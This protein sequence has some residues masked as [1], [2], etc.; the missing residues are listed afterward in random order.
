[1][2]RNCSQVNVMKKINKKEWTLLIV[3]CIIYSAS[4][5]SI[6]HATMVPGS[7]L[8]LALAVNKV[9]DIQIGLINLI[10]NIPVMYFVTRKMG[11]K[12]LVYTAFIMVSTS[13]LIDWMEAYAP[14]WQGVS[15]LVPAVLGGV[16]M[17]LGAGLLIKAGGTMAGTTALTL[18]IQ[19]IVRKVSFGTILFFLDT[20]IVLIGTFLIK[21]WMAFV[22]SQ[23]YS[24][25]C[26]RTMDIVIDY[27][28]YDT[29]TK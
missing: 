26:A 19:R 21:D 6:V 11:L 1:M 24:F 23:I 16:S 17:G 18:L 27:K 8:G 3:G 20:V 14:T 22:Y 10:L 4:A 15:Q 25:L 7:F 29:D 12:V 28:N 2:E 5:A 9:V 13:A